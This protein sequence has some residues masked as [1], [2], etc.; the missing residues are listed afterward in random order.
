[1]CE[2]VRHA[3]GPSGHGAN[4]RSV[5]REPQDCTL[6]PCPATRAP[7][8]VPPPQCRLLLGVEASHI[9]TDLLAIALNA[10]GRLPLAAGRRENAG[11]ATVVARRQLEPQP[12]RSACAVEGLVREVVPLATARL[13]HRSSCSNQLKRE[14]KC[15]DCGIRVSEVGVRRMSKR[16]V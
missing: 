14:H 15:R 5:A 7:A 16:N 11:V 10:D 2:S 4:L 3:H 13:A 8:A 9:A 1:M 6:P 12:A